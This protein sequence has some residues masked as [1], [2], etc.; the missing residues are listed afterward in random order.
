MRKV[1][2]AVVAVW[3]VHNAYTWTRVQ[4]LPCEQRVCRSP[5]DLEHWARAFRHP[6]V[7]SQLS[8]FYFFRQ[9][10][11]R[12][13]ITIP[14]WMSN[15]Q[16]YFKAVARMEVVVAPDKL[17]IREDAVE[18]LKEHAIKRTWLRRNGGQGARRIVQDL[19]VRFSDGET[20]Y[21]LAEGGTDRRAP[22]FLMPAGQ[23]EAVR[24]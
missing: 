19:Y 21:V 16:W 1:L 9:Y 17:L 14:P 10:I 18:G 11:P 24:R 23:Y 8:H 5:R 20:E 3:I 7:S 6:R 13:R 22:L 4:A 2:V 12:T 15:W